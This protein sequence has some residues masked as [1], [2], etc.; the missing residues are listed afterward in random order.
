ML[1]WM[2]NHSEYFLLYLASKL[3]YAEGVNNIKYWMFHYFK[4]FI[5]LYYGYI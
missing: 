5:H 4:H 2:Q 3:F 1:Q